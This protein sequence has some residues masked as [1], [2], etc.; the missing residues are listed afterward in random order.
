MMGQLDVAAASFLNPAVQ[1]L[2]QA[3][4]GVHDLAESVGIHRS[5]LEQ[6]G[7]YVPRVACGRFMEEAARMTGDAVF[8]FDAAPRVH[9]PDRRTRLSARRATRFEQLAGFFENIS[10]RSTATQLVARVEGD[11]LWLVR[12]TNTPL[13]EDVWALELYGL[14]VLD[15]VRRSLLAGAPPLVLHLRNTPPAEALPPLWRSALRKTGQ[16][17][18]AVAVDATCLRE[19]ALGEAAKH[20]VAPE[21]AGSPQDLE[22]RAQF[23]LL[24][25]SIWPY[26][27]EPRVGIDRAA[28]A[29]GL[30]RSSF[31][32]RL[33]ALGTTYSSLV[34]ELRAER[35][36]EM[37]AEPEFSISEISTEVG[38]LDSANFTRAFRRQF[39]VSPTRYRAIQSEQ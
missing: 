7:R 15:Q 14:G 11:L 35:A 20:Q 16:P 10:R 38:Y 1:R 13:R 28:D 3:G 2:R 8:A 4:F 18:M 26:I 39:G 33:R 5:T 27:R 17:A 23:D 34:K 36:L 32:R 30:S 29:F 19:P 22:E 9:R 6:A 31:Q 37:L 24:A 12:V 21:V 25:N